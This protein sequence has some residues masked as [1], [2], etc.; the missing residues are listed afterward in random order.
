MA[1]QDVHHSDRAQNLI[2][3]MK[4]HKGTIDTDDGGKIKIVLGPMPYAHPDT[5]ELI[6][7]QIWV[8]AFDAAGNKLDIDS[9]RIFVYPPD[10]T[11]YDTDLGQV[12]VDLSLP[13]PREFVQRDIKRSVAST[14]GRGSA[15]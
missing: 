9:H 6:G 3:S 14:P 12:V 8:N 4:N 2:R 1:R 5:G 7:Y 13:S 15:Q 10:N 11:Y